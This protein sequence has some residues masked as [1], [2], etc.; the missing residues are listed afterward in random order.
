HKKAYKKP[1]TKKRIAS[2]KPKKLTAQ[3][4]NELEKKQ[5]QLRQQATLANSLA[6]TM[7]LNTQAVAIV[8]ITGTPNLGHKPKLKRKTGSSQYYTLGTM[9]HLGNSQYKIKTTLKAGSNTYSVAG[10]KYKKKVSQR[11]NGKQ[12]WLIIDARSVK[13]PEFLLVKL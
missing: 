12:A 9:E 3:E 8:P 7:L 4:T 13:R 10:F 2:A 6:H 5:S 1:K 11:D